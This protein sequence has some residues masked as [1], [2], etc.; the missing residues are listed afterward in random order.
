MRR[1]LV[2][3]V[4]AAPLL[5]ALGSAAWA[6]CPASGTTTG[7]AGNITIASGCTVTPKTGAAGVTLNSNNTVTI[8]SGGAITNTDVDNTIGVLVEGGNTGSV[9]S[10]GAI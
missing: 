8:Q 10:T 1:A 3:A 2:A 5:A 6:A 9:D 4:A 7:G